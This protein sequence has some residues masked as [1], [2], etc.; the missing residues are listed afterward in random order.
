M[1]NLQYDTN[2]LNYKEKTH[3]HREQTCGC[4]D[5]WE[6]RGGRDREFGISGR[7]RLYIEW[8]DNKVL[9]HKTESLFNIL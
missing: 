4:Q 6:Y 1:W 9:Q 5:E 2:E 7:K 8:I 3:R